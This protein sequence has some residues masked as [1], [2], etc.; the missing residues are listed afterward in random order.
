MTSYR[1]HSIN[2]L[3]HVNQMKKPVRIDN[4][5]NSLSGVYKKDIL[6]YLIIIIVALFLF[7]YLS[8]NLNHIL[9]FT[10][11]LLVIN[12]LIQRDIETIN[13]FTTD[14]ENKLTFLDGFLSEQ[15]D[16][17]PTSIID[18]ENHVMKPLAIKSYLK[19]DPIIVNFLYDIR[20][21][22]FYNASVYRKILDNVNTMLLYYDRVKN[23][24]NAKDPKYNKKYNYD[25]ILQSRN[26]ALNNLHS[27]IYT[28]KSTVAN[29][30]KYNSSIK[31]FQRILQ[32]YINEVED[33]IQTDCKK[34]IRANSS[35]IDANGPQSNDPFDGSN[36]F[37]KNF[38][39]F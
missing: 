30:K 35:F 33:I 16:E 14:N 24:E 5:Y 9:G 8:I 22:M 18:L 27:M 29:N 23:I 12:F 3:E 1:Y 34:E 20:E 32:G 19:H 38:D 26:S 4:L 25:I 11:S 2:L 15:D 21:Y 7:N 6:N 10:I 37:N 13:T 39:F 17:I 28:S 31:L 36:G